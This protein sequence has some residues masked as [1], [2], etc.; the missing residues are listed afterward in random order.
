MVTYRPLWLPP[1]VTVLS[2][3]LRA[4][5]WAGLVIA[6]VCV[7]AFLILYLTGWRA[8]V[9][10]LRLDGSGG[11]P[12][13]DDLTEK[14]TVSGKAMHALTAIDYGVSPGS[15]LEGELHRRWR[16]SE[17][18]HSAYLPRR[19]RASHCRVNA[20]GVGSWEAPRRLP[21][22][23]DCVAQTLE[24]ITAAPHLKTGHSLTGIGGA[25][26]LRRDPDP[27]AFRPGSGLSIWKRADAIWALVITTLIAAVR[28]LVVQEAPWGSRWTTVPASGI[29][30]HPTA[31]QAVDA[32]TQPDRPVPGLKAAGQVMFLSAVITRIHPH[33]PGGR[34]RSGYDG[35]H[36]LHRAAIESRRI[37]RRRRGRSTMSSLTVR[38]AP[39]GRR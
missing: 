3:N 16:Q 21:V 27:E 8:C 2:S 10:L 13:P 37:S 7:L 18:L 36:H 15:P 32:A 4:L 34:L 12:G 24:P 14:I 9:G 35:R 31:A 25:S 11:T 17:N 28:G 22:I 30:A 19:H 20:G 39:I 1:L 5:S 26:A 23:A 33:I 6:V 38:T 29:A